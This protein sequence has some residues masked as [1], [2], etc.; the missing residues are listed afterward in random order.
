MCMD[1]IIY[2]VYFIFS[3]FFLNP[4]L[5]L[6]LSL[7][8]PLSPLLGVYFESITGDDI[9][10]SIRLRYETIG[11]YWI[12]DHVATPLELAGPRHVP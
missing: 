10:F 12:L 2:N 9:K 11:V 3:L 1:R 6:S 8:L 7:S 4:S 5:S